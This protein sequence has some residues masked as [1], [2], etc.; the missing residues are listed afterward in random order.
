MSKKVM[1]AKLNK[2]LELVSKKVGTRQLSDAM[3][4]A[5]VN[6]FFF[7]DL[8][9]LPVIDGQIVNYYWGAMVY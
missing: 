5:A 1:S 4:A 6:V 9:K 8:D 7:N 2:F 3:Y